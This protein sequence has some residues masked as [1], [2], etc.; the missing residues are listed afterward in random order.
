MDD[1]MKWVTVFLSASRK[2]DPEFGDWAERL[3]EGIARAGMGLVYGGNHVGPMGRLADGARRGGGKVVG[4]TPHFFN[5]DGL[6]DQKCDELI[7]V[8]SMRERK[9]K[10]EA[11]GDAFVVLPGGIGTLE[12]FVEIL[13]GRTLEQHVKPIVLVNQGGFWD[14]F[15]S[16]LRKQMELGFVRSHTFEL[17]RVVETPEEAVRWVAEALGVKGV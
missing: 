7:L 17:L 9:A 12:E 6:A 14:D 3:G 5:D 13:V 2:I 10:L 16:M 15:L 8:E 11:R 4:I 1:G